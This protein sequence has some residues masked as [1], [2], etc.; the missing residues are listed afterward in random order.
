MFKKGS[1]FWWN[2]AAGGNRESHKE[3]LIHFHGLYRLTFIFMI[4]H[5]L[6]SIGR[7]EGESG[8]LRG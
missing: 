7:L 4:E 2:K 5:C 8:K 1:L 6:V 3:G